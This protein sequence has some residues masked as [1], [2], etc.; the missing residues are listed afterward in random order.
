[1]ASARKQACRPTLGRRVSR[2]GELGRPTQTP[3]TPSGRSPAR[4]TDVGFRQADPA[5][6][7]RRPMS[8]TA[9]TA[10]SF[11]SLAMA[12]DTHDPRASST[13]PRRL[14]PSR[15]RT[16]APTDPGG[17]RR[18]SSDSADPRA[19]T[20]EPW[21][22]RQLVRL[23]SS[24]PRIELRRPTW[25]NAATARPPRAPA[26]PGEPTPRPA[27]RLDRQASGARVRARLKEIDRHTHA[28]AAT[29]CPARRLDRQTSALLKPTSRSR[30]AYARGSAPRPR[31]RSARSAEP[32]GARARARLAGPGDLSGGGPAARNQPT[33]SARRSPRPARQPGSQPQSLG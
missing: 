20:A 25:D 7:L 19:D 3:P 26:D 28:D 21:A 10:Q 14:H 6:A 18:R 29:C 13:D 16:R 24:P 11:A 23:R 4:S 32:R 31:R 2:S 17:P 12:S 9:A 8:G 5:L 27:R 22:A 15:P 1:M 33:Q 30:S